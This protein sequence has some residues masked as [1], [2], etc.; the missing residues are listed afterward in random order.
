MQML[1]ITLNY[2]QRGKK[3][4]S[5]TNDTGN[6]MWGALAPAGMGVVRK[7]AVKLTNGAKKL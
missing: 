2:S 3:Q 4:K 6:N 5:L 7:L 1:H